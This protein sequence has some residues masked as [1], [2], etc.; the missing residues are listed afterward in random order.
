MT[1]VGGSADTPVRTGRVL[2][3]R[4]QHVLAAF[5]DCP[6]GIGHHV[7]DTDQ[8]PLRSVRFGADDFEWP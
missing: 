8:W 6:V 7:M 1:G 2:I 5:F 3:V 4:S